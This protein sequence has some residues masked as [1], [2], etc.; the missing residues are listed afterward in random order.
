MSNNDE[1]WF[2]KWLR[3]GRL[4]AIT[5]L[6][7]FT[8]WVSFQIAKI[9]APILDQLLLTIS[10]VLVG[11]LAIKKTADDKKDAVEEKKSKEKADESS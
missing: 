5:F 11:N 10:G 3:N 6:I 2:A 9:Q 4:S 7:I 1:S 8:T